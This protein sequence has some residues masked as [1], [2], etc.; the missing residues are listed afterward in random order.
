MP[1]LFSVVNFCL[2]IENQQ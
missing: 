1:K 2:K